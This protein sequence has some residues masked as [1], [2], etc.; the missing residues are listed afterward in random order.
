MGIGEFILEKSHMN[1]KF[2]KRHLVPVVPGLIIK[3]FIQVKS[4]IN[5]KSVKGLRFK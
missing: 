1:M 2:V 4:H 5:V 3:E